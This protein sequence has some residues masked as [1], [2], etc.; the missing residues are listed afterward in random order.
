MKYFHHGPDDIHLWTNRAHFEAEHGYVKL[1]LERLGQLA[2]EFPDNPHIIY[3]QA[4]LRYHHAGQGL[5]AR[6]LFLRA[7]ECSRQQAIPG[8]LWYASRYV[9]KL[10]F[11]ADECR[12]WAQQTIALAPKD[13]SSRREAQALLESLDAVDQFDHLLMIYAERA[14]AEREFGGAAAMTEVALGIEEREVADEISVRRSR[15]F[16][17]R[18]LDQTQEHQH[19]TRGEQFPPEDRI[20]LSGALAEIEKAIALDKSDS[21]L[22]NFASLWLQ[23]LGRSAEAIN[24]ADAAIKLRPHGYPRPWINRAGALWASHRDAEALASA[25]RAHEEAERSDRQYAD[26]IDAAD[27]TIQAYSS[28]RQHPVI[29]D[30]ARVMAGAIAFAHTACSEQAKGPAY[31]AGIASGVLARIAKTPS[32]RAISFVPMMAQLLSDFAPEVALEVLF[33]ASS[34]SPEAYVLCLNAAMYLTA[35]CDGVQQRDAARFIIL[36]LFSRAAHSPT[37][38]RQTYREA[39]YEVAVAAE[40]PLSDLEQKLKA[41]LERFDPVLAGLITEQPMVTPSELERGR[42]TVMRHF[43]GDPREFE[44]DAPQMG[45]FY[46]NDPGEWALVRAFKAIIVRCRSEWMKLRGQRAPR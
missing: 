18:G 24:A 36:N 26:A 7:A 32:R 5:L 28:P 22:W 40:P 41:E 15:A 6:E 9:A 25:R 4:L 23:L 31:V 44:V 16:W 2:S 21:E 20:A 8:T 3:D 33:E 12:C 10:A 13:H 39:V 11:N 43:Y 17:L 42:T 19:T 35:D 38:V 34:R 46:S 37:L 1:A 29:E 30:F 14:A 27:R 45:L